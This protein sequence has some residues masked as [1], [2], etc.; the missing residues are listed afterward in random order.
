LS[1]PIIS[2]SFVFVRWRAAERRQRIDAE[3]EE[4]FKSDAARYILDMRIETAVFVDDEDRRALCAALEAGEIS[5]H[6]RAGRVV[7]GFFDGQ[8]FVIGGDDRGLRIIVLQHRQQRQRRGGRARDRAEPFHEDA[9]IDDA[10]CET[11][12]EVDDTLFH[13]RLPAVIAPILRA[14][15]DNSLRESAAVP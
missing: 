3:G 12:V 15:Y 1:E 8:P 10:M 5:R 2:R 7:G 13:A 6:P 11:V 14:R 4:A 9:A